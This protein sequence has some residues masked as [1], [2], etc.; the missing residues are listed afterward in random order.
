M[1]YDRATTVFVLCFILEGVAFEEAR[2]LVFVLLLQRIN[3]CSMTFIFVV[4]IFLV[5]YIYIAIRA[6][7]CCRG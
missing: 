2:L 6:L 5:V 3:H 7:G 4:L 1:I